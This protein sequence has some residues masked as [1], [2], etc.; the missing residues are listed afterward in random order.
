M[1]L[2]ATGHS[3]KAASAADPNRAQASPTRPEAYS[4][5]QSRSSVAGPGQQG[6]AYI[7]ICDPNDHATMATLAG[8][9]SDRSG[10]TDRSSTAPTPIR[11]QNADQ[12]R[13]QVRDAVR[14]ND[15]SSG[16]GEREIDAAGN[17]SSQTWNQGMKH[18]EVKVTGKILER[19][20]LQAIQVASI[21]KVHAQ[22]AR[23]GVRRPESR[24][25]PKKESDRRE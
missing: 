17:R 18:G 16:I 2:I 3:D 4:S 14:G 23:S 9:S 1:V 6:Q 19:G 8:Y 22:D 20:G 25:Q 24:T 12:D 5:D 10:V 11:E 13:Q 21:E 15:R 7:L